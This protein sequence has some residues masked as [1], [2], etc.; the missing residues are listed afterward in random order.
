MLSQIERV[1][2]WLKGG[3]PHGIPAADYV[4]LRAATAWARAKY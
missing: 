3:Y 4:P 2:S 1:V